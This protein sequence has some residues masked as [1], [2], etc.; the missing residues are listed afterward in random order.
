MIFQSPSSALLIPINFKQ[1]QYRGVQEFKIM[2]TWAHVSRR[3]Q[4]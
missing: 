2:E 3:F 1:A 4:M